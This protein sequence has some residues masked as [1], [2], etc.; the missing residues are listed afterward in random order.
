MEERATQ[1]NQTNEPR[2]DN[3]SGGVSFAEIVREKEANKTPGRLL[4]P[5]YS[6]VKSDL[7]HIIVAAILLVVAI[8]FFILSWRYNTLKERVF[9]PASLSFIF[10]IV[11]LAANL[12]FGIWGIVGLIVHKRKIRLLQ[13]EAE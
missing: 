7:A 4:D 6:K 3:L 8:V 2:P 9:T 10:S 11:C 1:K 12:F 5:L 13:Q